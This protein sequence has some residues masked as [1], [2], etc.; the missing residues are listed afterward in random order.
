MKALLVI[1]MVNDFIAPGGS[2]YIGPVANEIL[3]RVKLRIDEYRAEGLPV[4]F[5]CDRHTE[6]DIEFSMFPRHSIKGSSGSEVAGEIAPVPGE[7][8]IEKR[9]FSAFVGTD[10]DLTLRDKKVTEI[11]LVGVVTNICILYTAAIARMY[12]YRVSVPV[13]AVASFDEEAH[14][15]ALKEMEKSL[16]VTLT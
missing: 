5:I 15:F 4:I 2:L 14:R 10:L 11:E 8:V 9:R 12:G 13:D 6:D 1:D 16:G 3:P 7:R